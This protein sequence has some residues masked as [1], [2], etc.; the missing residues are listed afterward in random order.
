MKTSLWFIMA[1]L[2]CPYVL[3]QEKITG[4]IT[5]ENNRPLK[6]AHIQNGKYKATSNA[7]GKF[8]VEC[9]EKNLIK[10]S[11]VG[12]ENTQKTAECGSDLNIAM[13]ISEIDLEPV[14]IVDSEN[15]AEK[16]VTTPI[17][18]AHLDQKEI[19]RYS[20]LYLEETINL[21][22]GIR[23]EKRTNSGGQRITIRG[24]GNN[25][26]FNGL[27][28][29]LY[30]DGVPIT[31]AEGVTI[32]DAMDFSNLGD[33]EIY[34]GPNSSQ[35]GTGI[36]GFVNLKSI[37][38]EPNQTAIGQE[39][40]GGSYGMLRTNTF[41]ETATDKMALR[42]NYGHQSFD[43]YR[44]HTGSKKNY[45]SA[46]ASFKPNQKQ[47]FEASISYSQSYE[48]LA[49]QLDSADFFNRRNVAETPYI[50]NDGHVGI[51]N[52]RASLSHTF[53]FTKNISNTTK[54]FVNAYTL[55]QTYAV[56]LNDN[57]SLS[58]GGRTVFDFS[59]FQ[60]KKVQLDGQVGGEYL[61]TTSK[62]S[63][64]AMF[65]GVLGGLRSQNKVQAQRYFVFT[66]WTLTLPFEIQITA[67][68]SVNF[69]EYGITDLLTNSSN[70]TH[71]DGS[72]Y[73]KFK[74]VVTPRFSIQKSWDKKYSI[75]ASYSQGYTAPTSSDAVIP[76]TGQTN[77]DLKAET[78]RQYELGT[79]GNV[80]EGKLNYE[81][82]A[83]FMQIEN[84]LNSK[85][86]TDTSGTVLYT[87]TVNGGSQN[88]LGFEGAISYSIIKDDEK[89]VSLLRPFFNFTY[90]YF[91][92]N[93]FKSDANNDVNTIDYSGNKVIGVPPL[94]INAGVDLGF[95]FGLYLNSSVQYVDGMAITFNNEHEAPKYTLL[96][97]KIGYQKKWKH[98]H[99]DVFFG[100]NNILNSLYYNMVFI[101][102]EKG[103]NPS[104]YSP[105]APNP[106]AYG[107]F[108]LKYVF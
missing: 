41:I 89:V 64:S 16:L 73:K 107:G 7:E 99:L 51:E 103:P 29:K 40:V 11:F 66:E 46:F 108:S 23:M 87:Y 50:L 58:F 62:N 44:T 24:Y 31:D 36:A 65:G 93:D 75:Y 13:K 70:P 19:H 25:T 45:A 2:F 35:F 85:A 52:L 78:A 30:Y 48:K 76:Y 9:T 74:P 21:K 79:K 39:V 60:D 100:V 61:K 55:N 63:G 72:G 83:F 37:Q 20:G 22:T 6:G 38:P 81:F 86:V 67:G 92:Y 94:L 26:N 53:R 54:A 3:S 49:G 82:A 12:Y 77:F 106:T 56:G 90:S 10:I 80:L 17:A 101:N 88:N 91:R 43:G 97:A 28:Y 102:W 68:A 57:H 18:I 105:A 42:V 32:M 33:V 71:E 1:V 104:I 34:K 95:K 14:D 5:G 96:N 59:F 98:F 27:G 8:E 84:K 47:H 4:I 15:K 69:I